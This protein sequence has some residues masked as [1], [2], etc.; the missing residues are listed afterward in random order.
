M[1]DD[2]NFP[3]FEKHNVGLPLQGSSDGP[4]EG[5]VIEGEII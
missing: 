4:F 1:P 2:R 5:H 3:G